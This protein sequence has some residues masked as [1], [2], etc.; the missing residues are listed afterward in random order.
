MLRRVTK[1]ALMPLLALCY[2][3]FAKTVSPIVLVAVFFGFAGDFFLLLTTHR[4]AFPAGIA[5]FAT[6]HACYIACFLGALPRFPVYYVWTA[7]G[8]IS[9]AYALTLMRYLWKGIPRKLRPPSIVYMLIIGSMA[10]FA[11]IYAFSRATPLCWLAGIGGLL[12]VV[13]DSMLSID[14]FHHPIRHRSILVMS[15]YIAAQ[16]LIVSSLAFV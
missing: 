5:A 10:S 7:L 9:A 12:F 15:T 4:W 16:T 3:L 13:S 6:G 2:V 11:M 8:L 14:A 1:C